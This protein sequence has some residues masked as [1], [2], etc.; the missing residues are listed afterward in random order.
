MAVRPDFTS[1][2][3]RTPPPSPRSAPARRA[4]ARDRARG[5]PGPA[6]ARPRR[7]SPASSDRLGAARRRRARPAGAPADAARRDR[8]ELRPARADEDRRLFARLGVFAGGCDLD[9]AEAGVRLPDDC[10]A[11]RRPRRPRAPRRPEP[12]P[13]RGRRRTATPVRDARDDPR[14]R[15]RAARRAGRGWTRSARPPRAGVSRARPARSRGDGPGSFGPR[16]LARPPRATSTTTSARRWTGSWR[17]GDHG[18]RGGPR[19][20]R[21]ALLADARPPGRGSIPGRTRCSRC[22]AGTDCPTRSPDSTRSRPPAA[23]RTGPVTWAGE[24]PLRGGGGG[25]TAPGRRSA[26]SPTR[27]TTLLR[28]ADPAGAWRAGSRRSRT[29]ASRSSTRRSRSGPGWATR[30][31]SAKAYWGLGRAPRLPRRVRRD[32]GLHHPGARDLRAPRQPVL[33][34]LDAVHARIRAGGQRP[35]ARRPARTWRPR[36]ASS[37]RRAT[38]RGRAAARRDVEHPAARR[39]TRPTAMPWAA[40]RASRSPRR[41]STWRRSGRVRPSRRRSTTST[42]PVLAAALAEGASWPRDEAVARALALADAIAAGRSRRRSGVGWRHA[43]ARRRPRSR[44]RL[45]DRADPPSG[46]ADA[47]HGVE[48]RIRP[49]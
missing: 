3:P 16:R 17:R 14:V 9:T 2:P 32:R 24:P 38:S 12:G 18:G 26:S 4:A 41:G 48:P 36:C 6:P 5:G 30:R 28:D 15:P 40:P 13:D 23:S 10:D 35:A 27:S 46:P 11:A 22:P 42:D 21:V 8:L 45:P 31:A 7:S 1:R 33:D 34:R 47:G 39:T 43:V 25:G 19:A 37:R 20:R 29:R 49:T 44:R